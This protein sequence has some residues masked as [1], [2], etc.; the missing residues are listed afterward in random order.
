MKILKKYRE[1]NEKWEE[2]TI[3][4]CLEHTE[5]SGYWKPGTVLERLKSGQRVFTPFAEYKLLSCESD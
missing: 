3:G 2:T 5:N 1:P 4:E